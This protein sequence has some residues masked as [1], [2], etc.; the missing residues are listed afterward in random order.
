MTGRTVVFDSRL[1]NVAPLTWGGIIGNEP[2]LRDHTLVGECRPINLGRN[3]WE[4]KI[5]IVQR[6]RLHV[7]P[8]TWG[9]I[10]GN[11]RKA[12]YRAIISAL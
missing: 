6:L 4:L 3:H 10:I 11:A 12:M 8:L 9:G 7:A 2:V 5:A 1:G